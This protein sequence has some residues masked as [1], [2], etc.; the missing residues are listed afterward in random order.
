LSLRSSPTLELE[1]SEKEGW[2]ASKLSVELS[3]WTSLENTLAILTSEEVLSAPTY[4]TMII[5][6]NL[7]SA[8][9][10]GNLRAININLFKISQGSVFSLCGNLYA[11][12]PQAMLGLP[13]KQEESKPS[14]YYKEE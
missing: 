2:W 5:F 14:S 9:K 13:R 4:A 1:E 7:R 10:F 3:A 6:G 8:K 12:G 11:I